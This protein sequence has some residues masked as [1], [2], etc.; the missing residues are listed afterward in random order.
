MTSFF[1]NMCTV[2]VFLQVEKDSIGGVEN[3]CSAYCYVYVRKDCKWLFDFGENLLLR[4]VS[5]SF[6]VVRH[7]TN[8]ELDIDESEV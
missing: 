7:L 1:V 2:I 4:Y 3:T 6:G 5:A 8:C